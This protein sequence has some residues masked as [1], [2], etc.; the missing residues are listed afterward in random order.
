MRVL[1]LLVALA[2]DLL[3]GTKAASCLDGWISYRSHCYF[4]GYELRL[5]FSTA[6]IYCRINGAYLTRL[7][8]YSEYF[9]LKKLLKRTRAYSAWTSLSDQRY[10]GIWL[11]HGTNELATF[12][13]WAPGNPNNDKNEDCMGF[14]H[15]HGYMWND[16]PCTVKLIPIC[17]RS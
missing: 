16:F 5:P 14:Y 17:E 10:E 1:I 7:D 12:S 4:V 9:F 3:L 8:T 6:Q 13:D 11:W 2:P 15:R